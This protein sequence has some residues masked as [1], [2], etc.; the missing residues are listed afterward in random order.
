MATKKNEKKEDEA[1]QAA[2]KAISKVSDKYLDLHGYIWER[3]SRGQL[4]AFGSEKEGTKAI[5]VSLTKAGCPTKLRNWA[6]LE[7]QARIYAEANS[8]HVCPV[9]DQ[10]KNLN[11]KDGT[12]LAGTAFADGVAELT[13]EGIRYRERKRNEIYWNAVRHRLP[14]NYSDTSEFEGFLLTFTHGA[15]GTR[16]MD[17][18][19]ETIK[20]MIGAC[21]FDNRMQN[22]FDMN[23]DGGNGKGVLMKIITAAVGVENVGVLKSTRAGGRFEAGFLHGKRVIFLNE[24][25][26]RPVSEHA[27]SIYDDF[28]AD[29]KASTGMDLV[30]METKYKEAI[31]LGTQEAPYIAASNTGHTLAQVDERQGAWIRRYKPIPCPPSLDEQFRDDMLPQVIVARDLDGIIYECMNV[32]ADIYKANEWPYVPV[33]QQMATEAAKSEM[34]PFLEF[35]RPA[36]DSKLFYSE[37]KAGY[38][39]AAGL[40]DSSRVDK[41]LMA[42]INKSLATRFGSIKSDGSA[43]APVSGIPD[44]YQSGIRW[45]D[46][47]IAAAVQE[48]LLLDY[49]TE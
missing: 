47:N 40:H 15:V 48:R 24:M 16:D 9:G 36:A 3:N 5:A 42:K 28:L 39:I 38:C 7:I 13:K 37:L 10:G 11:A 6:M 49:S 34:E 18:L 30:P 25:K 22:F 29:I 33:S 31:K 46:G 19:A 26:R 1:L 21:L 27:E 8:P 14:R 12:L 43:P 23:G 45:R 17:A 4:A 32:F 20:G 35:I 41:G 44:R 2:L